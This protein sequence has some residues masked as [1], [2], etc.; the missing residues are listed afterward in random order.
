MVFTIY[1]DNDTDVVT[2]SSQHEERKGNPKVVKEQTDSGAIPTLLKAESDQLFYGGRKT[3]QPH[4]GGPYAEL[5]GGKQVLPHQCV[6][7]HLN[8]SAEEQ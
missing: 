3:K 2:H 8:K 5:P 6:K 4:G 7:F 1:A